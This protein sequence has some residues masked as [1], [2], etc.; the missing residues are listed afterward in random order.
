MLTIQLV[1]AIII[2]KT[3]EVFLMKREAY[4]SAQEIRFPDERFRVSAERRKFCKN[5]KAFHE[6]IEIKC[7]LSGNSAVMIDGD[8]FVASQGNL[9]VVNPF[10]LHANANI[11]DYSGEYILLMVDLDFLKGQGVGGLD[12]RQA[13]ISRGRRI[14]HFIGADERLLRIME[15]IC[16][17]LAEQKEDYRIAVR[18]L[19]C[20]LFIILFR[21]HSDKVA[22]RENFTGD[23]R[24]ANLIAPALS[25]IFERHGEQISIDE[26]AAICN[27]SKYH[28]CRVF[29]QEMKMTVVQYITAY[30]ISLADVMLKESEKSIDGIAEECGFSDISYFYRCYKRL[31]GTSPKKARTK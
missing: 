11:G 3:Q 6:A 17:E 29:K 8:V 24:G 4:V 5:D 27:V 15:R 14:N 7:Y 20:E 28:F 26:L 18:S 2:V 23:G 12:L 13:F 1:F 31:R 25:A 19:V 16:E 22:L 10:E 9:T 21:D 30:R